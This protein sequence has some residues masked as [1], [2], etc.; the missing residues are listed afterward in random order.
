MDIF[1]WSIPFVS[2]K[3]KAAPSSSHAIFIAVAEVLYTVLRPTVDDIEEE[4]EEFDEDVDD[5]SL[6][7]EALFL[8]E[9]I[10]PDDS[11]L[12]PKP[13]VISPQSKSRRYIL[14]C[15]KSTLCRSRVYPSEGAHG[16]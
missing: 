9:P 2:E 11:R 4:M 14:S 3:G 15:A 8:L 5:I 16:C 12:E 6:P 10:V 13:A 7:P 1:M